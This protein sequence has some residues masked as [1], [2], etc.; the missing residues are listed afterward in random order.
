MVN[1]REVLIK[2]VILDKPKD[3]DRLNPKGIK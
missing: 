1:I 2:I 3:A